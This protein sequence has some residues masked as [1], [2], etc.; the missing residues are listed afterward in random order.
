MVFVTFGPSQKGTLLARRALELVPTSISSIRDL[1]LSASKPVFEPHR[2]RWSG[3]VRRP[4]RRG[5]ACRRGGQLRGA[6][7][8]RSAGPVRRRA[9]SAAGT[10]S[11]TGRCLPSKTKTKIKTKTE[12][13][14]LNGSFRLVPRVGPRTI[15]LL[16]V[17][18][19]WLECF[20]KPPRH[21]SRTFSIIFHMNQ[22]NLNPIVAPKSHEAPMSNNPSNIGKNQENSI[23]SKKNT[24]KYVN[25]YR[26]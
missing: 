14:F 20:E 25:H 15:A 4:S 6:R 3:R 23:A 17:S 26:G 9:A 2:R 16:L 1:F 5:R 7:A 22:E 10:P 8:S 19:V 13:R 21:Q 12:A 11:T 18:F 24:V